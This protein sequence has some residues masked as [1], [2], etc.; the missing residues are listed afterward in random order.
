MNVNYLIARNSKSSQ[1]TMIVDISVGEFGR[2]RF[3][4]DVL[5]TF[6]DLLGEYDNTKLAQTFFSN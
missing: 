3:R 1:K 5:F 2:T 6:D 4:R